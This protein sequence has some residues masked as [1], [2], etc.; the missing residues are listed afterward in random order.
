L[1]KKRYIAW[2][3]AHKEMQQTNGWLYCAKES[4]THLTDML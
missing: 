4:S 1:T 2:K 3:E